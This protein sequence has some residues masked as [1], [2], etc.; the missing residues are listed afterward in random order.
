MAS[1]APVLGPTCATP[2]ILR[3]LRVLHLERC[4]DDGCLSAGSWA[5]VSGVAAIDGVLRTDRGTFRIYTTG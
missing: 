5:G 2:L 3:L 4:K 1:R